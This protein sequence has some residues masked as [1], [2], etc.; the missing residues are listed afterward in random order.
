[1]E[2]SDF[3]PGWS[4][5][6]RRKAYFRCRVVAMPMTETQKHGLLQVEAGKHVNKIT[7]NMD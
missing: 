7:V 1:M 5:W 2:L 6:W 3:M 4:A